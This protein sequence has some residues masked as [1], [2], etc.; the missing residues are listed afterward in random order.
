VGRIRLA[1]HHPP[2]RIISTRSGR[3]HVYELGAGETPVILEAGIAATSLSWALV[4]QEAAKFARVIAY[5]RAGLGWSDPP[6]TPRTPANIARELREWLDAAEVQPPFLL[7]GH[8]F[9]GLVVER[10]AI[11]NPHVVHGLILVDALSP[12]EFCPLSDFSRGRLLR[13]VQLSRRGAF[14][15]RIGVV[16]A[17]LSLVLAGNQVLPKLAARVS[18]G[19]G[20]Q[21]LTSRLAGEIR[22]LPREL[23]PMI[24][25][26]WAMPK[27]FESMAAHLE[28]LPASCKEM[29]G[30]Q[31][32]EV[33]VTVISAATNQH[34]AGVGLPEGAK[35]ITAE[36]SGH[37]IQLDEPG[38]VVEAIRTMLR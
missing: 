11:E 13:A 17:C 9:G 28:D 29:S 12:A 4:Q 7:V 3:F 32:P 16:G 30:A 2:G 19:S 24:A 25:S 8:S 5:D 26:H 38:L 6:N 37:W 18:S 14:L 22:K 23:W 1:Q 34:G 27:S 15:A 35:L 20:G 31:L 33:P 36:R 10:F 21:G